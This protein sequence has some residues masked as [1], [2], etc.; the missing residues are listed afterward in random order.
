MRDLRLARCIV[1]LTNEDRR[2]CIL[3]FLLFQPP[4]H[5]ASSFHQ[6]LGSLSTLLDVSYKSALLASSSMLIEYPFDVVDGFGIGQPL[7]KNRR[8]S[9]LDY[10]LPIEIFFSFPPFVP[11]LF[12]R[13]T[14]VDENVL[15]D[16][17][18]RSRID[19]RDR[20]LLFKHRPIP[21][22]RLSNRRG[23]KADVSSVDALPDGEKTA[24]P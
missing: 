24:F 6:R 12:P 17:H 13:S 5:S 16:W 8:A 10:A 19:R 14:V 2:D 3:A 20:S 22:Y 15:T 11:R 9:L 18:S 4:R 1:R 7:R 21:V 23:R